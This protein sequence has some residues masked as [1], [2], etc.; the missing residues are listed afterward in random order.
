MAKRFSRLEAEALSILKAGGNPAE[1]SDTRVKNYWLWKNESDQTRHQLLPGAHRIKGSLVQV[2]VKP[3]G[4]Q[5]TTHT[6]YADISHRAYVATRPTGITTAVLGWQAIPAADATQPEFRKG[7]KPAQAFFRQLLSSPVE[8][9]ASRITRRPYKTR[10][11]SEQQGYVFPFGKTGSLTA[12]GA[13][14]ETIV[15]ALVAQAGVSWA[16]RFKAE[17]WT[18]PGEV[19]AP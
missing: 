19:G 14:E 2:I 15:T 7:Y 16:V 5:V 6:V 18:V 17:K 11:Q 8:V 13:V 4:S 3:F 1:S 10:S 9:P 12:Q